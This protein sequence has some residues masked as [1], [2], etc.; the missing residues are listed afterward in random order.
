MNFY[1]DRGPFLGFLK[2]NCTNSAPLDRPQHFGG[3]TRQLPLNQICIEGFWH[4][5]PRKKMCTCHL[6]AKFKIWSTYVG[7]A[8]K[9]AKVY[10]PILYHPTLGLSKWHAHKKINGCPCK[11][12]LKFF[13]LFSSLFHFIVL[14]SFNFLFYIALKLHN[15]PNTNPKTSNHHSKLKPSFCS[16]IQRLNHFFTRFIYLKHVGANFEYSKSY[17]KK[18]KRSF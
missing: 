11:F 1:V 18:V 7:V 9:L 5:Y 17:F 15:Q 13:S 6:W 12:N 8:T 10:M 14:I 2:T 4:M 16:K 3:W